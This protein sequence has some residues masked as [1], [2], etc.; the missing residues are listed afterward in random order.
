IRKMGATINVGDLPGI[1]GDPDRLAELFEQLIANSLKFRALEP[2]IIDVEAGNSPEGW[3][4]RVKDNGL[5]I[6]AQYR[7]RLFIAFRRLH[8]AEVPGAGLGLAISR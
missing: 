2:P 7:N 5:G 8:G 1:Q 4:F 6:P 3:V